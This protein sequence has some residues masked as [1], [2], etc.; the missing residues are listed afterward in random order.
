MAQV[1]FL[2]GY[3]A[4]KE[5][6]MSL[7]P[8]LKTKKAQ[9]FQ[10]ID[11]P[12]LL[13]P[14]HFGGRSWFEINNYELMKLQAGNLDFSNSLPKDLSDTLEYINKNIKIAPNE[15][16][17][18]GGFS[19]GSMCALHFYLKYH[20]QYNFKGIILY[21]STALGLKQ[22]QELAD[23]LEDRTPVFQSHGSTDAVLKFEYA[24]KLKN[25]LIESKFDV[26][27]H[28][29]QGGHQ[30]PMTILEKSRSFI[31]HNLQ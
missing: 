4:N 11:A 31:E 26:Q 27:F 15:E 7:E 17:I 5:D 3:G 1:V 2:H 14:A 16:L 10:F 22:C 9:N 24:K 28:E 23:K 25:F 30:I 19:Q 6:L 13:Q 8:Y 29:F 18:L 21:S 12:H 20:D